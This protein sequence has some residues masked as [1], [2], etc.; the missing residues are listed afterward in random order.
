MP[1][2]VRII[3]Y[4]L[5]H[6]AAG[7]PRVG[8]GRAAGG[9]QVRGVVLA[10]YPPGVTGKGRDATI[11]AA[12][13]SWMVDVLVV[14]P[15]YRTILYNVPVMV[16]SGGV[17]NFVARVPTATTGTVSGAALVISPESAATPATPAQDMNG[18][19]VLLGFLGDDL[20][21]P[22]VIGQLAHPATTREIDPT[23][24]EQHFVS[25]T[26][27][28]IDTLGNVEMSFA[29]SLGEGSVLLGSGDLT[30]GKKLYVRDA[31]TTNPE[32]VLRGETYLQ[33]YGLL[34]T[35]LISALTEITTV[36][37]GLGGPCP[38]TTGTVLP[39]LATYSATVATSQAVGLP[40]LS[41]HLEVD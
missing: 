4:A 25:N 40:Y 3:P 21:Q 12:M 9:L 41:S 13:P 17:S 15:T 6:R 8:R 16:E 29:E 23:K 30:T 32:A 39:N 26:A 24:V 18:D 1:F 2:P 35:D 34:L 28:S 22:Y 27:W 33:D 7:E 37:A 20:N 36:L 14:E 31:V 19:H 10:V 11:A 5:R 38:I